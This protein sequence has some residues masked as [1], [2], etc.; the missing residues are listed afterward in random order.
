MMIPR[1]LDLRFLA[2]YAALLAPSVA[3]VPAQAQGLEK[4]DESR[5]ERVVLGALSYRVH[6]LNCH[7]SSGN[8]QGP[9]AELLKITPADLTRLAENNDGEFPSDKIY[10]TI[11]G[12]EE[13]AAHGSRQMPIWGIGFQIP[14]RDSDQ[15]EAVRAK[16]LDLV[17]YLET[18][19]VANEHPTP[20]G[21]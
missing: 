8:G 17:A 15:E 13:I 5:Q 14:G 1:R 3:A 11:D 7:G 21:S 6:C 10:R 4:A 12:R 9:M 20:D 2:C 18:L 16:I 19:Q